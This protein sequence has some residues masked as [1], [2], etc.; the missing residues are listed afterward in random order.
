MGLY[1]WSVCHCLDTVYMCTTAW[2][3]LSK[4]S[5]VEAI[6]SIGVAIDSH[7]MVFNWLFKCE[8]TALFLP[9]F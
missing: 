5:G 9:V 8:T 4:T 6:G 1:P 2:V 7:D 3:L